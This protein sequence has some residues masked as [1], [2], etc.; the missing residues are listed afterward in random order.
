MN[1]LCLGAKGQEVKLLQSKL[2]IVSDGSFGPLTLS[3]VKEFQRTH[4]LKADGVVS[5]ITW[6]YLLSTVNA[7][8]TLSDAV[9]NIVKFNKNRVKISLTYDIATKGI[10]N[11]GPADYIINAG[12]YNNNPGGVGYGLT[13]VDTVIDGKVVGGGNYTTIG[14][15]TEGRISSSIAA[16]TERATLIGFSPDLLPN[17]DM[18][19]LST[20]FMN[21]LAFRTAV[22]VDSL[23]NIY[24]VTTNK[25]MT[26]YA[27]KQKLK[28]LGCV[29]AGNF[30]GGG[31]TQA[32]LYV[33]GVYYKHTVQTDTRKNATYLKVN[34]VKPRIA[35]DN[36]HGGADPGAVSPSQEREYDKN[37]LVTSLVTKKLKDY[38]V[39]VTNPTGKTM[40]LTE[41]ADLINAFNPD[42]FIS[43]HHN[44]EAGH[45]ARGYEIIYKANTDSTILADKLSKAYDKIPLVK[46]AIYGKLNSQNQ[47]WYGILRL[48]KAIP[49]IISEAYY[50]SNPSDRL[51][52]EVEAEAITAAIRNYINR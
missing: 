42:L 48:T 16:K 7:D 49:G 21:A 19:G 9:F 33:N 30:D 6:A 37:I 41:R 22:G 3:K 15:R 45:T 39:L 20:A 51:Q 35:I 52:P 17:C 2:G 12:M 40:S 1:T 32:A 10:R 4:A 47:E 50:M 13:I 34:F 25:K 38:D 36:G 18:K 27:I 5:A 46:H 28:D 11:I 31:S 23:N 14:F 44:S 24:F 8:F 43:I 26:V 29:Q